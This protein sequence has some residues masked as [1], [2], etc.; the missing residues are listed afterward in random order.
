MP[1]KTSRHRLKLGWL[2]GSLHRVDKLLK[3]I[4]DWL[5]EQTFNRSDEVTVGLARFRR[6]SSKSCIGTEIRTK[7]LPVESRVENGV[8]MFFGHLAAAS[9]S[10]IALQSDIDH[11]RNHSGAHMSATDSSTCAVVRRYASD[12]QLF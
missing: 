3:G 1:C 9:H 10:S 8:A 12:Q 6:L 2:A 11:Q 5:H 4:F 7:G